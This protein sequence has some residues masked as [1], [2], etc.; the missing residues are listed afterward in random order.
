MAVGSIAAHLEDKITRLEASRI[1]EAG[2]LNGKNFESVMIIQANPT[3]TSIPSAS[4]QINGDF[5]VIA[6]NADL[7]AARY[8]LP[9]DSLQGDFSG[10]L[11]NAGELLQLWTPLG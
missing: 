8:D 2:F 9:R 4:R 3:D 5:L 11:D 1:Q 7:L 6:A 10:N